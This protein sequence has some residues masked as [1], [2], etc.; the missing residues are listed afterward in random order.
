MRDGMIMNGIRE[1]AGLTVLT[2][3][4]DLDWIILIFLIAGFCISW[5]L[6]MREPY[7]TAVGVL[8]FI[9]TLLGIAGLWAP[10][11]IVVGISMLGP[12]LVWIFIGISR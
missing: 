4:T 10:P 1:L 3:R 5:R 9:G 6:D 11:N 2:I 12:V 7:V 8:C